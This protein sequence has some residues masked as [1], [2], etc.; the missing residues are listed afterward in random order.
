MLSAAALVPSSP[1]LLR[2]VNKNH[3][4]EIESTE[5]ALEHLSDEWY[6]RKIETVVIITQSRFGYDDAI[7]LD[8][9]DP[10]IMDLEALGDLSPKATYHPDFSLI[11][12][13]QRLARSHDAPITLTTEP[14]L[15]YGCAAPLEALARRIPHIRI[16]PVATAGAC[17]AKEH[18]QLGMILKQSIISSPKRIGIIAAGDVSLAHLADI[19][20]ILEEKS[21][22]SLLKLE[23]ELESHQN[24]AAYRPL[25]TLFGVLDN[26]PSRAEI[27]SI[28]SP[29]NVGYVVATF[30]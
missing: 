7:S 10:Y 16:M 20:L 29:F 22:A 27:L 30:T 13:I 26:I 19:R 4:T 18:Y 21:T 24:D 8:V 6:A 3:R 15:P 25:A 23:P 17:D 9:A 28:E 14:S 1:L 12:N 2:T 11:D 5:E